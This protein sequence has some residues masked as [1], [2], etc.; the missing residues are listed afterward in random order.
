[1]IV[2]NWSI[3]P[4]QGQII[5]ILEE[6]A[7]CCQELN[8]FWNSDLQLELAMHRELALTV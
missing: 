7:N 6:N 1:M 8:F 2:L 4:L 5:I 3:L